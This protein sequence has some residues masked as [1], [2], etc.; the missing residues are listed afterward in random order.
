MSRLI[1]FGCSNTYGQ[2]LPDCHLID[3]TGGYRA[4]PHPSKHA[5]PSVLGKL[6]NRETINLGSPGASNRAIWNNIVNFNFNSDDIVVCHW[7][8]IH[9]YAVIKK[10]CK[11]D[12]GLWDIPEYKISEAWVRY[13]TEINDDYDRMLESVALID[14]ANLFLKTRV[15]VLLNVSFNQVEF[16][17]KPKWC[18][19]KFDLDAAYYNIEFPLALDNAHTGLQGHKELAKQLFKFILERS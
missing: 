3:R 5:W 1:A 9:R 12:L 2:G 19:F 10:D 18:N 11:I 15:P 8:L 17:N 6:L 4:G 16:E 14:H 7:S 13:I